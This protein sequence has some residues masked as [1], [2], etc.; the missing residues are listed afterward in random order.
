MRIN[1]N[2]HLIIIEIVDEFIRAHR[3]D[4]QY[5]V[6]YL[7]VSTVNSLLNLVQLYEVMSGRAVVQQRARRFTP[8]LGD[9]DLAYESR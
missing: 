6:K 1:I 9:N 4:L 8:I 3:T 2:A 7:K 5:S